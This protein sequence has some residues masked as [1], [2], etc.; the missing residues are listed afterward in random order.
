MT[1]QD[2][3]D[4][5]SILEDIINQS[6]FIVNYGSIDRNDAKINLLKTHLSGLQSVLNKRNLELIVKPKE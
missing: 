6:L 4:D 3:I 5:K 1:L 2:L